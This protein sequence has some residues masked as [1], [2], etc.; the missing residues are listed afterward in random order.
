MN[1]QQEQF[2][3]RIQE[4]EEQLEELRAKAQETNEVMDEA[5]TQIR[6]AVQDSAVDE[7]KQEQISY[8][9]EEKYAQQRKLASVK[10]TKTATKLQALL[11]RN[12]SDQAK[13]EQRVEGV[14]LL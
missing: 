8:E 1:E 3:Q 14:S 10:F 4:R 12:L 11:E 5:K 13:L 7:G 2:F 6:E 9:E